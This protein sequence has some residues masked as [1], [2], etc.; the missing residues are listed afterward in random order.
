MAKKTLILSIVMLILIAMPACSST[1]SWEDSSGLYGGVWKVKDGITVRFLQDTY[2]P[3]IGTMTL[4]FENRT[5][6]VMMF[7]H[8]WSFQRYE[9]G[10][11]HDL[12]VIFEPVFWLVGYMLYEHD[13][14]ALR[15]GTDFLV[16]PLDEGLHRLTGIPL[17]I[18]RGGNHVEFPPYQIEFMVSNDAT[19]EPDVGLIPMNEIGLFRFP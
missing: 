7:G 14:K 3:D 15:V 10:R 5:E 18:S 8:G 16:K 17:R 19:E 9:N 2:P 4:V 6:Y 1:D 13:R 11:W 12:E